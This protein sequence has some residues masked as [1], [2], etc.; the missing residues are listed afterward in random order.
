MVDK[1]GNEDGDFLADNWV[2]ISQPVAFVLGR[3][4]V[5]KKPRQEAKGGTASRRGSYTRQTTVGSYTG[6]E[7]RSD[8]N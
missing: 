6:G 3:L 7:V 5:E 8:G 2:H 4:K 1:I